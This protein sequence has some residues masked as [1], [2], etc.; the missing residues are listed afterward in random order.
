MLWVI[1]G[2]PGLRRLLVS[3]CF[4]ASLP[5]QAIAL[6]LAQR[7]TN[8]TPPPTGPSAVSALC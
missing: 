7:S 1:G 3:Y 5:C 6:C 8:A 2:R 4:A